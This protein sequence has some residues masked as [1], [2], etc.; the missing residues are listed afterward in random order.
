MDAVDIISRLDL[1]QLL[2]S[3]FQAAA[4][5]QANLANTTVDFIKTFAFEPGTDEVRTVTL[6][7]FYDMDIS[8]NGGKE[9]D[10]PYNPGKKARQ[11]KKTLTIPFLTLLNVP[12]LQMQKVVVDLTVKVESQS[13]VRN[14]AASTSASQTSTNAAFAYNAFFSSGSFSTSVNTQVSA[15]NNSS[16]SIDSSSSAKY[17]IH[18][19][20]INQPPI[21]LSIILDFLTSSSNIAPNREKHKETT[22]P[23][24]TLANATR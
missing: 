8:A 4:M 7:S 12:A 19:E 10:D 11:G 6:S 14:E 24:Y 21:G 2:Y 1:S 22:I 20:A 3:P 23:M 13:I 9:V 17:D 16:S 15:S 18:M 5:A